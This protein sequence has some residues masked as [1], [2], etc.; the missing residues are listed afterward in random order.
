MTDAADAYAAGA[1][2]AA[3]LAVAGAGVVVVVVVVVVDVAAAAAVGCSGVY[4]AD[5][6]A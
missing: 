6:W 2:L 1:C 4:V 3:E 5:G